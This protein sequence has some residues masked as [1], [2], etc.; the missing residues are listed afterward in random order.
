LNRYLKRPPFPRKID[1]ISNPEVAG[2]GKYPEMETD[3]LRKLQ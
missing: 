3:D 2:N 1:I